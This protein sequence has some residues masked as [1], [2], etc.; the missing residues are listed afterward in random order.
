MRKR[1]YYLSVISISFFLSGCYSGKMIVDSTP[2]GVM[3]VDNYT[4]VKIED[5]VD[6]LGFGV[7]IPMSPGKLTMDPTVKYQKGSFEKSIINFDLSYKFGI[8]GNIFETYQAEKFVAPL[9]FQAAYTHPLKVWNKTGKVNIPLYPNAYTIDKKSPFLRLLNVEGGIGYA[10]I[11]SESTLWADQK[12]EATGAIFRGGFPDGNAIINQGIVYAHLGI[13]LSH[14]INTFI[15][16]NAEGKNYSGR[17]KEV[18]DVRFGVRPL[19]FSMAPDI[20]YTY[21]V[22]ENSNWVEKNE[23]V[24]I[25]SFLKKS[26]IGYNMSVSRTTFIEMNKSLAFINFFD[27]G[28]NPGYSEKFI[29]N[30]YVRFGMIFGFIPKRN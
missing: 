12:S 3:G 17:R 30:L 1:F 11:F 21:D 14:F 9:T 10:S 5:P 20:L 8:G 2:N 29:S 26:I 24:K 7:S 18:W 4:T 6:V 28:I 27:F 13:R 15:S 25:S 16:G 22:L 19:I 23:Y